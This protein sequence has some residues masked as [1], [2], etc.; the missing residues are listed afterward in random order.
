MLT[1]SGGLLPS[2]ILT[3]TLPGPQ[4]GFRLHTLIAFAPPIAESLDPPVD[5]FDQNILIHRL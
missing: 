5:T 4:C 3:G 2:D 1:A